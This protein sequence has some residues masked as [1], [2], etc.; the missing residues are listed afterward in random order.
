[1]SIS[2]CEENKTENTEIN[3]VEVP[4]RI[5]LFLGLQI[6][7]FLGSPLAGGFQM[8][9]WSMLDSALFVIAI[10]LTG[11]VPVLETKK[12]RDTAFK[13]AVAFYL[14]G[15]LDTAINICLS[16]LVGW[17]TLNLLS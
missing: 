1:M 10:G 6:L 5:K 11:L 15:V 3:R 4:G 16:G 12:Q 8:K 7:F 14:L 2:T 17:K 9:A 13:T